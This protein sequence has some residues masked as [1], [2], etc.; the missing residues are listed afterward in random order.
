VAAPEGS[1]AARGGLKK[2]DVVK[3][4][5]VGGSN[6]RVDDAPMLLVLQASHK[7][8]QRLHIN[9]FRDHKMIKLEIPYE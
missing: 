5:D 1:K 2:G 9:V 3:S 8:Q 7:W 4:V 6:F